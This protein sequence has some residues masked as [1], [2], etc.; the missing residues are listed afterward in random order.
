MTVSDGRL[1]SP[2]PARLLALTRNSYSLPFSRPLATSHRKPMISTRL[3]AAAVTITTTITAAW[4]SGSAFVSIN[5]VNLR[6][7]RLVL[8][9]VTVSGLNCRCGILS[10]YVTSHPDQLSVAI[11][12]WVGAMSS[13]QRAVTPCDWGVNAGM[14][15]VWVAVRITA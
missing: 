10:W 11:P 4:H 12:S 9:W 13:N 5:E 8:G 3:T 6:R 1:G 14:V 15:R 7:A 2:R